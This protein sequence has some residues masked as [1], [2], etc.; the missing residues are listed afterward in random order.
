MS[1]PSEKTAI[2]GSYDCPSFKKRV[3]VTVIKT[4]MTVPPY[5]VGYSATG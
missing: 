2:V 1:V 4:T 5:F 3:G